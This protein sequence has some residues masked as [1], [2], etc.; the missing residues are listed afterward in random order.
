MRITKFIKQLLESSDAQTLKLAVLLI[1]RKTFCELNGELQLAGFAFR[2]YRDSASKMCTLTKSGLDGVG[3][4]E[5]G[6]NFKMPFGDRPEWL[7]FDVAELKKMKK[8]EPD[9]F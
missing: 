2:F 4:V 3:R 1:G 9:S 5:L 6:R 7:A 8:Y